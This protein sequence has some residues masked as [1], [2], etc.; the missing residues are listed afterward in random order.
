MAKYI[1]II[2]FYILSFTTSTFASTEVYRLNLSS[3]TD[4]VH[5]VNQYENLI[6]V[7]N[8][9]TKEDFAI[10]LKNMNMHINSGKR[11]L[12]I[13]KPFLDTMNLIHAALLFKTGK[14]NEAI[15]IFRYI[16]GTVNEQLEQ[17]NT[18]FESPVTFAEL[19]TVL[20][21]YKETE[22]IK[23]YITRYSKHLENLKTTVWPSVDKIKETLINYSELHPLI[24]T[25]IPLFKRKPIRAGSLSNRVITYAD[26]ESSHYYNVLIDDVYFE[27]YGSN[28]DEMIAETVLLVR[29][30]SIEA[31]KG[32]IP[33]V[34]EVGYDFLSPNNQEGRFWRKIK[35]LPNQKLI[36]ESDYWKKLKTSQKLSLLIELTTTIHLLHQEGYVYNHISASSIAVSQSGQITPL[37][38]FY[39]N[40]LGQPYPTGTRSEHPDKKS[41]TETSDIYSFGKLLYDLVYFEGGPLIHWASEHAEKSGIFDLIKNTIQREKSKRLKSM[42]EVIS[43][44]EKVKNYFKKIEKEDTA[45]Y[46]ILQAA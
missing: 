8:T 24:K 12:H 21:K 6:P 27:Y 19:D 17:I 13:G 36:K 41:M 10:Y 30:N 16:K 9:I 43:G 28:L 46:M 31:L 33:E 39:T 14:V 40:L 45:P 38:F 35:S 32:R 18:L 25:K 42:E 2:Y 3:S 23:G 11:V 1:F 37:F 5:L 20:A 4:D 7:K 29:L 26:E 44:L 34:I 15:S 22:S